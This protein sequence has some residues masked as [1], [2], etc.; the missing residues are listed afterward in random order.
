M[1]RLGSA[2]FLLGSLSLA[3]PAS[4]QLRVTTWNL[5]NFNGSDAGR[6]DDLRTALFDE[7]EGRSLRPDVLVFQEITGASAASRLPGILN[8]D[9]RGGQDWALATFIDGP[10]TDSALAYRTSRVSV[11]DVVVASLGGGPPRPPRNT[12][13]Y[14]LA[15]VGYDAPV[16]SVYSTHM[17]AGT[18]G[19]D[20]DRREVEAQAIRADA[21]DLPEGTHVMLLGDLN[22]R[23]SNE[24]AYES[25]IESR[26]DNNGRFFDPIAS[27]GSWNDSSLFRFIHTQDPVSQM[28]DRFDFIMVNDD[29]FDGDGLEYV[30]DVTR[31]FSRTT[32]DDPNHS[33]RTW[34]NDG[35][36]FND[37]ISLSN[38]MVG[39][40][41]A[42][43][44]RDAPGGSLGHL[45]V[46]VDL[47][48]PAKIGT[49]AS[50]NFGE[51]DV[52]EEV[53][54]DLPVGNLGSVALWTADGIQPLRFTVIAPPPFDTPLDLFEVPAGSPTEFVPITL[55]ATSPG[56]LDTELRIL[57]N[58]PDRPEA[59]VRLT[60]TVVGGACRADFDGN[61]RLDIFDFLAFQN[62]FA[63]GDLAADFDGDGAL[64]LFDF[65]AFQNEFGAG[66]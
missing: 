6:N 11:R 2:V 36:S 40:T 15:L 21:E 54:L 45:P 56:D 31:A 8:A 32:F 27:P 53:T 23:S 26:P 1:T 37:P 62:A 43:A 30:G 13:R 38:D 12:M 20:R 16:L 19:T 17:K 57:S 44:L 14:D 55:R 47:L 50:L 60:A 22:I 3:A 63:S 41:I 46:F 66:C 35:T 25:L 64:T 51:V 18:S 39:P 9:P 65:L 58:D 34:G 5:T 24:D 49:L 29:L 48:V 7:F 4:A 10:T 61:G 52:G 28:D 59:V 33:Y 42:R